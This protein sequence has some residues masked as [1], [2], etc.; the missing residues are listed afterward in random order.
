[1]GNDETQD[2]K[3]GGTKNET[4]RGR[5]IGTVSPCSSLVPFRRA[6]RRF[7]S[8]VRCG[9]VCLVPCHV[10]IPRSF[11]F[12]IGRYLAREQRSKQGAV[13]D[14]GDGCVRTRE[15]RRRR[16]GTPRGRDTG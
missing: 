1:M 2:E 9:L 11:F 14:G 10:L 5:N 12:L 7:V 16:Y 6:C 8:S 13:W 15:A 3:K 4:R